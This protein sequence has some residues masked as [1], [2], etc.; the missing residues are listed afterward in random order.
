[1]R[2]DYAECHTFTAV[3][4]PNKVWSSYRAAG[5]MWPATGFSVVR[6]NIQEISSNLKFVEMRVRGYICLT[7]LLALD[8]MCICIRTMNN[9]FSVY[10]YCFCFVYLFYNQIRRYGP[11]TGYLSG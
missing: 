2:T 10:H 5:R 9:S 1:M 11:P 8:I 7:E 4:C 3:Q 6:G